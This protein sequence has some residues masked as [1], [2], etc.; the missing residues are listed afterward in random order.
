MKVPEAH[1]V[2]PQQLSVPSHRTSLGYCADYQMQ[3]SSFAVLQVVATLAHLS[4]HAVTMKKNQQQ[5]TKKQMIG[6]MQGYFHSS[7]SKEEILAQQ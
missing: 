6:I 3:F 2:L 5:I 7:M 1:Q 4:R